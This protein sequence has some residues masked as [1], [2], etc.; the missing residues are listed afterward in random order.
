MPR[1]VQMGISCSAIVFECMAAAVLMS[2]GILK[3]LTGKV[4]EDL[5]KKKLNLKLAR[6]QATFGEAERKGFLCTMAAST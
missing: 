3:A 4:A 6:I 5:K 2:G 1:D